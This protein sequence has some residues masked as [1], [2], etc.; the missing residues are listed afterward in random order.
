MM[1]SLKIFIHESTIL[2]QIKNT[3]GKGEIAHNDQFP[4]FQQC[5]KT[6]SA[7]YK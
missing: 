1:A 4:L 2:K 7:A 6:P 3:V 5:F